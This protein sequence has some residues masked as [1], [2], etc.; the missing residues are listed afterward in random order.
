[1][2]PSSSCSGLASDGD[3]HPQTRPNPKRQR[4]DNIPAQG[5]P[6]SPASRLCSLGWEAGVEPQAQRLK[7]LLQT[8]HFRANQARALPASAFRLRESMCPASRSALDPC[9]DGLSVVLLHPRKQLIHLLRTEPLNGAFNLLHRTHLW[10]PAQK[11]NSRW[12]LRAGQ[13]ITDIKSTPSNY[14]PQTQSQIHLSSP[15]PPHPQQTK[16]DR[17]ELPTPSNLL[18]LTE[19]KL[20]ATGRGGSGVEAPLRRAPRR[21]RLPVLGC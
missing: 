6:G 3:R 16:R 5:V 12:P 9:V 17:H 14:F 4:R 7:C 13:S 19:T 11:R 10:S 18:S 1:M 15:H 2:T 20:K 8:R 21:D